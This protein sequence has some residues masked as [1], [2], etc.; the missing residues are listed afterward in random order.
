MV[1]QGIWRERTDQELRELYNDLDNLA[2]INMKRFEWIGHIARINEGSTVKKA[3][4]IKPEGGRGRGS[5]KLRCLEDV[6]KYLREMKVPII[7]HLNIQYIYK[8]LNIQCVALNV[9]V[10]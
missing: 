5:S 3:F 7:F 9:K 4:E 2:D 8:P 10:Y 1:E 6:E